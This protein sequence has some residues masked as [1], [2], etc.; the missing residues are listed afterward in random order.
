M[1][2]ALYLCCLLA[3]FAFFWCCCKVFCTPCPDGASPTIQVRF[4]GITAVDGCAY[5]AV[6][7]DTLFTLPIY[8]SGEGQR[9][10]WLLDT[11]Y[12]ERFCVEPFEEMGETFNLYRLRI[13]ATVE[14]GKIVLSLEAWVNTT[15]SQV[16]R[17]E[18]EEPMP[19][20][21]PDPVFPE[22][23]FLIRGPCGPQE[24]ELTQNNGSGG[25]G[26]P[27]V[28]H[29]VCDLDATQPVVTFF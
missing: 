19:D 27:D 6:L 10:E 21:E 8:V 26:F 14:Q 3:P 2:D 9:C 17:H 11:D 12:E 20:H 28:L 18:W 22:N 4:P 29:S 25:S 5:C 24:F 23:P 1:L 13:M 16:G 7:A 15:Q